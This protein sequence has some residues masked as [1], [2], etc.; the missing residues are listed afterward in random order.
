MGNVKILWRP[1]SQKLIGF[2]LVILAALL[3]ITP[4][5]SQTPAPEPAPAPTLP[6]LEQPALPSVK[7]AGTPLTLEDMPRISKEVLKRKL[8]VDT[9]IIVVDV[10][11]KAEY[12]NSHIRGSVSGPLQ[13]IIEGKWQPPPNKEIIFY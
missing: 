6:V 8:E 1:G 7:E 2:M 11:I 5:C 10:R 9:S 13:E 4:A 12:A 3:L